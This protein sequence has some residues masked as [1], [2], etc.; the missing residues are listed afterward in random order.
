MYYPH[1][2][3]PGLNPIWGLWLEVGRLKTIGQGLVGH[4]KGASRE[5]GL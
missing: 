2:T 5:C 3:I 4:A 1:S